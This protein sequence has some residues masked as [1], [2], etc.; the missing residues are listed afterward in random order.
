[1]FFANIGHELVSKNPDSKL[2]M[3]MSTIPAISEFHLEPTTPAA[4]CKLMDEISDSKA[5]SDDGVPYNL[6]ISGISFF[7]SCAS[8]QNVLYKCK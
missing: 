5:P 8:I 3:H 6:N 1:M 7:H 4:V 2:I